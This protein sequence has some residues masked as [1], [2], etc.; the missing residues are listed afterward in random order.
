MSATHGV[1]VETRLDGL[2]SGVDDRLARGVL[3]A[4][5]R[6]SRGRLDDFGGE[7]LSALGAR[8]LFSFPSSAGALAFLRDL[9]PAVEALE[10]GELGPVRL[11]AAVHSGAFS[12]SNADG[13]VQRVFGDALEQVRLLADAAL[14]GQVLVSDGEPHP[15]GDSLE[16]VGIAQPVRAWE[17][18][19]VVAGPEPWREHART[20]VPPQSPAEAPDKT[21]ERRDRQLVE[22]ALARARGVDGP[23]RAACLSWLERESDALAA[24]FERRVGSD[25]SLALA[26]I[27]ALQAACSGR[28]PGAAYLGSLDRA[29][30]H[31]SGEARGRA[32]VIRA[33]ARL[34]RGAIGAAREDALLALG[35]LPEEADARA[36]AHRT[37]GRCA[38]DQ[39]ALEEAGLELGRTLGLAR[40]RGDRR[41]EARAL[42]NLAS[43]SFAQ[44]DLRRARVRYEQALELHQA[45]ADRR[46][47]GIALGNLGGVLRQLGQLEEAETCYRDA[48]SVAHELGERYLA[49]AA[50]RELGGIAHEQGRLA[51]AQGLVEEGR[52]LLLQSG[53]RIQTLLAENALTLLALE[54]G[55]LDSAESHLARALELDPLGDYPAQRG[56]SSLLRALL[57]ARRGRVDEAL[58]T[59]AEARGLLEQAGQVDLLTCHALSLSL[60]VPAPDAERI[61]E[62][63][64]HHSGDSADVR[65]LLRYAR[66]QLLP[67]TAETPESLVQIGPRAR[68]FQAPGAAIVSLRRKQRLRR[69]LA[70][71]A[72]QR[73]NAPGRVLSRDALF[74][75]VWPGEKIGVES[76]HNRLYV[77]IATLRRLGLAGVL[78]TQ[79]DGYL[80][81]AA[82]TWVR[83][84]DGE[85]VQQSG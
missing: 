50:L 61:L 69:L 56:Q 77:A 71:L 2:G 42:N 38:L 41:L 28:A 60:V 15:G 82:A 39:S 83:S 19:A 8:T 73:V 58:R 65:L 3:E 76:A 57:C 33:E 29:V 32:L 5:D 66:G 35:A 13:G 75:A 40:A 70:A 10:S 85:D 49:G 7:V 22:R 6:A 44:A 80:L 51:E 11:A 12:I 9:A 45:V 18:A 63:V 54:R 46:Y 23:E 81:D 48:L 72:E 36:E 37:L 67:P 43:V 34:S 20:S 14:G 27:E 59:A 21:R 25:P 52:A 4:F 53:N 79:T 68:W 84:D 78:H 16:L 24:V 1:L 30:E 55:D 31:F 47:E 62:G 17:L 74:A 26:V 64:E